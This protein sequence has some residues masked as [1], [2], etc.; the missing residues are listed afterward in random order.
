MMRAV[1]LA[2]YA[3]LAPLAAAGQDPIVIRAG[4]VL[5]GRGGVLRAATIVVEGNRIRSVEAGTTLPATFDLSGYTLLPGLIDTHVHIDSHFGRDGRAS[6]RGES[7][8][9]RMLHGVENAVITLRA[10]FTTVQSI[11]SPSDLE[12]RDAI[13][14]GN[15]PAPRLLT[16]ISPIT[17]QTGD[18]AAIR[19]HV[20]AM[21]ERGADLIKIFASKS[22]REGGAQTLSDAQIAAACGEARALG[23]RTWVH[24][25]AASAAR[26]AS[27]AGCTTVTHGS[28]VT[29]DVFALMVERGTYFEPNIGL[30]SQNYLENRDRY[31]GI[32]NY[33]EEGFAFTE[34]GIPQKLEMFERALRFPELKLLAG[35]DATAGAHGQNAREV[36]YRVEVA[37]QAPMD[38]LRSITSVAAG[39]LGMAD[40][41]GAVAPGLL[42]DLI[43]V[44]GDPLSDI[45]A[46]RRV[47]FVMKDGVVWK[48]EGT[49]R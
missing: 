13:A 1:A 39:A 37:G 33:T 9:E 18:E 43:A 22:I 14:R 24:A 23:K 29:D 38:A 26:A 44:D 41:L 8:T 49:V 7:D 40:S 45:G 25:H 34:R 32:G 12:L 47:V 10:G 28:Q 16:S 35:T 17:E 42:A 20:H 27:L 46:L 21:V 6:N 30:V 11:G 15:L 2:L 4:A 19:Q 36:I 3:L 48:N 5:D 31:L